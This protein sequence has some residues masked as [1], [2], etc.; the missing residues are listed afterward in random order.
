MEQAELPELTYLLQAYLSVPGETI[1][2]SL[3]TY[4]FTNA[5][6]GVDFAIAE[7]E[8]LLS[9]DCSEQQ[10]TEFVTSNS[11]HLIDGSGINT[12]QYVVNQLRQLLDARK[13]DKS[14]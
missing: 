14:P 10:V 6:L 1:E 3:R 7:I 2:S 11:L 4:V 5:E 12:L 8:Q 9:G 13:S